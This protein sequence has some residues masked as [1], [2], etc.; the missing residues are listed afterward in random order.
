VVLNNG[1]EGVGFEHK[2]DREETRKERKRFG[3]QMFS[4]MYYC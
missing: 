2:G 3:S 1:D 4:E